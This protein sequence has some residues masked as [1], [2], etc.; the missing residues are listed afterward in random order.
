MDHNPASTGRARRFADSH[1]IHTT[2]LKPMQLRIVGARGQVTPQLAD[3]A[4]YHHLDPRSPVGRGEPATDH[5]TRYQ[6]ERSVPGR[7]WSRPVSRVNRTTRPPLRWPTSSRRFRFQART[8]SAPPAHAR[9][10]SRPRRLS[11]AP[12][13]RL[14]L[15]PWPQPKPFPRNW[16]PS[17]PRSSHGE[18]GTAAPI[19]YRHDLRVSGSTFSYVRGRRKHPVV[20]RSD[21]KSAAATSRPP[22]R[23][24]QLDCNL[25]PRKSLSSTPGPH[26][27]C[28]GNLG[29]HLLRFHAYSRTCCITSA[30]SHRRGCSQNGE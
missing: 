3:Y 12:P 29:R 27:T 9:S 5:I 24:W 6:P 21:G 15:R 16:P 7:P 30:A 18:P 22:P 8:R 4:S 28:S 1:Q 2:S 23:H 26:A 11:S 25:R 13:T 10:L 19:D 20:R 17:P 14:L